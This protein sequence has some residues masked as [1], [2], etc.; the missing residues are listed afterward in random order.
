MKIV[1]VSSVSKGKK[2]ILGDEDY[3]KFA[4]AGR[5]YV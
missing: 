3:D 4:L 2:L 5:V 1:R